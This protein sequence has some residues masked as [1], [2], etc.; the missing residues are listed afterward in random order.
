M[1]TTFMQVLK[2]IIRDREFGVSDNDLVTLVELA[3]AH[4]E[5]RRKLKRMSKIV[6][7]AMSYEFAPIK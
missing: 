7:E 3:V 5:D 2:M 6:A 1:K 4:V